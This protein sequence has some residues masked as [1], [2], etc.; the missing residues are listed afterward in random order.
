MRRKCL[1]IGAD[2]LLTLTYRENLTDLTV[3]VADLT[4]FN[5]LVKSAGIHMP[6]VAVWELQNRG[7]IHWHLA[8]SGFQNVRVLR[9]LW[10]KAL[11]ADRDGNIDVTGPRQHCSMNRL[12]RYLS[13]YITKGFE[14]VQEGAHRFRC[15][16]GIRVPSELVCYKVWQLKAALGMVQEVVRD[17]TGGEAWQA[18]GDD[19]RWGV[20]YGAADQT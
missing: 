8:V 20:I 11:G 14:F 10:K 1:T 6:Y 15:S 12:A 3:A 7:A 17:I 13:K 16:L 5:R 4:R 19:G 2:H 9:T 18:T